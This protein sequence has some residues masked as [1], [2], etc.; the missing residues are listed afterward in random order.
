V[1]GSRSHGQ[2]VCVASTATTVLQFF[3]PTE[4]RVSSGNRKVTYLTPM[5]HDPKPRRFSEQEREFFPDLAASMSTAA[6]APST[7]PSTT[8]RLP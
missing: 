1:G 4:S 8:V 6:S 7:Y 3:N 5:L 2:P